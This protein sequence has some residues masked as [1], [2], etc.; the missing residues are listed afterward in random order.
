VYINYSRHYKPCYIIEMTTHLEE[1]TVHEINKPTPHNEG[2]MK[3]DPPSSASSINS[4]DS[5]QKESRIKVVVRKRPLN[6]KE[7]QSGEFDMI[8]IHPGGE[9]LTIAEPKIRVDLT[10][11]VYNHEFTF[12]AVFDC[13]ATNV[14]IYSQCCRPLVYK[15]FHGAKATCFAYG[16]TGSGKSWTMLGQGNSEPGLWGQAGKDIFSVVQLEQFAHLCVKVSYFEI[17][18]DK[19]FDL[20]QRR[21]ELQCREDRK[22]QVNIVGLT[23]KNCTTEEQLLETIL[24]GSQI[25]ATGVTGANSQSSRSHAVLSID[26]RVRE[27]DRAHGRFSFI[28]LAGSERG[29]DT[30]QNTKQTR[31]EGAEI[32][33]SLLALK[34]CIRALDMRHSHKPFRQSMLTR[35]LKESFIGNAYTLMIANVSPSSGSSEDTLNSLRYADR[36][37]DLSR[38]NHSSKKYNAYMPH[39]G[40]S[41]A[42]RGSKESSSRNPNYRPS[43]AEQQRHSL[44]RNS[45]QAIFNGTE[46]SS[47]QADANRSPT[48]HDAGIP[49]S[50]SST[51]R[52]PRRLVGKKKRN[53]PESNRK[54]SSTRKP[55]LRQSCSS[56]G[57]S[58]VRH[59][60]EAA[61]VTAAPPLADVADVA[62][63]PPQL[64]RLKTN[65]TDRSSSLARSPP[66]NG[67]FHEEDKLVK[68]HREHID[69]YMLLIKQDMQ[70]LKSFDH[71]MT[72]DIGEYVQELKA[73]LQRKVKSTSELWNTLLSFQ[74]E[75]GVVD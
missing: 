64:K 74:S 19:L 16:Q 72:V 17:Y 39:K 4:R 30:M 47:R 25:R 68:A 7:I 12:D 14:D 18:G 5:C 63:K 48:T 3:T 9:I 21:K 52:K 35:V 69:Q 31:R 1:F 42:R 6:E 66:P 8:K 58:S 36:V 2:C 13:D 55:M 41:T 59:Q 32:N 45:S 10:K 71:S 44:G 34:E 54:M 38:G 40:G 49:R 75:Q 28:D 20:L 43:S 67:L 61:P 27:T 62:M 37:K 29:A 56:P 53:P 57:S 65:S 11:F 26:L 23:V 46:K 24:E 33:K 22:Q 60:V 15:V 51:V 50:L 73:L 70:L